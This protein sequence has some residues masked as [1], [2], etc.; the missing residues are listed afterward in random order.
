[1]KRL[2]TKDPA[3]QY[4]LSELE[5]LEVERRRL[6]LHIKRVRRRLDTMRRPVF[7]HA[8]A[9]LEDNLSS[10]EMSVRTATVLRNAKIH[11]LSELCN[12]TRQ[13][14]VKLKGCGPETIK[15]IRNLLL[16]KGRLDWK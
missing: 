14:L 8:P 16:R 4:L 9:R 13:D 15:E 11:W 5:G 3:V 1:M 6:L 12:W 10:M 2:N 7:K